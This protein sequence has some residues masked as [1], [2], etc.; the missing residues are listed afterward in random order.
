VQPFL[1]DPRDWGPLKL[2]IIQTAPTKLMIGELF[3][4]FSRGARQA[5]ISLMPYT[6]SGF[7]STKWLLNNSQL[8]NLNLEIKVIT[9]LL[10]FLILFF[11]LR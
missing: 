10:F 9:L 8:F 1:H 2:S 5:S 3:N 11:V 4:D 6:A 7:L